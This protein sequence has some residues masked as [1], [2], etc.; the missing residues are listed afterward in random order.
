[1]GS[2]II[3]CPKCETLGYLIKEKPRPKK[4]RKT[5]LKPNSKEY[6]T[7][8][9]PN[10]IFEVV[11]N[12]KKEGKWRAKRCYLGVYQKVLDNMKRYHPEGSQSWDTTVIDFFM[13]FGVLYNTVG[14][15]RAL[16][17]IEDRQQIANVLFRFGT[18]KFSLLHNSP[19]KLKRDPKNHDNFLF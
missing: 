13:D 8:R 6:R 14:S 10:P 12:I 4:Y 19:I 18:H 16:G 11:H 3:I 17:S 2:K 9:K 5:T 7:T 1:M 15:G